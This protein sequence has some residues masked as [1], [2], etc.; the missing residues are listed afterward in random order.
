[1]K[2]PGERPPL[3]REMTGKKRDRQRGGEETKK[4]WKEKMSEDV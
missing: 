4:K 3:F 1:M 2:N